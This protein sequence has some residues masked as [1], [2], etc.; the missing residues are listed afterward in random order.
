MQK[1]GSIRVE[2]CG[3][4]LR[5]LIQ[6]RSGKEAGFFLTLEDAENLAEALVTAVRLA[7]VM[8]GER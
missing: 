2:V 5:I 8:A 7:E 3:D 6:C 1:D 4:K